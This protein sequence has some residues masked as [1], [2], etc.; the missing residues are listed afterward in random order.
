MSYFL[1]GSSSSK[2]LLGRTRIYANDFSGQLDSEALAK[3]LHEAFEVHKKNRDE[4]QFLYDY[5]RGKQN[6]INRDSKKIRPEIDNRVVENNAKLVADF[7]TGY[8]WGEPIQ[9]IRNNNGTALITK[10][11]KNQKLQ[12]KDN[13]VTILNEYFQECGK[14]RKDKNCGFWTVVC[15]Q[16]YMCVL[17]NK[18][19]GSRIPFELR[20][21]SPLNTFIVYSKSYDDLP[22]M[23]VTYYELENDK[24]QTILKITAY[25]ESFNY[26]IT[27]NHSDMT[28][29]EVE[30][31]SSAYGIP[32]VEFNLNEVR[33]GGFEPILPLCDAINLISS[34]RVNDVSQAVQWFMKFINVDLDEE[35]YEK[36][37]KMGVIMLKGEPGNPANVDVVSTTLDQSQ[38]Q[39]LKED[40][41]SRLHEIS[42]VPERTADVG[43][44]TGQALIVGQ[45]W[46][47]AES[48]AKSVEALQIDK[49]K[50]LVRI[51]LAICKLSEN[52]PSELKNAYVEDIEIKFT[53]N[54]TD[55]LLVKT[56]GLKNML[57]SGV[58]PI[59]AFTNCGLF[60]DPQK[61]Y[62][63]SKP[64]LE[65][66][67]S[68][69]KPNEQNVKDMNVNDNS[70]NN[71][72]IKQKEI[73]NE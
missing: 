50:E 72:Q 31:T 56:Q 9:L 73:E 34:D 3:L 39:V 40:M 71:S 57:D 12:E 55:N 10:D 69:K 52:A 18:K 30:V 2:Q 47:S 35:L 1:A 11:E 29:S 15:G 51:A 8:I 61:A 43:D 66:F 58:A 64:Y 22:L 68:N 23:A 4:I 65:K 16:G 67:Y 53:R 33:Q 54:R 21:L 14:T 49:Q 44:N 36:F 17:P 25:T 48:D 32:I 5:Y 60:S 41:I 27:Y 24:N 62:E 45:G 37:I 19:Q 38:I 28:T 13:Q 59:L 6:I 26:V 7:K 42:H 20:T 46:A 70:Y 63:L